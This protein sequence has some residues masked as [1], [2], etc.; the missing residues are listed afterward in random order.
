[1][2]EYINIR[3][4]LKDRLAVIALNL[5]GMVFMALF[6]LSAGNSLDTVLLVIGMWILTAVLYFAVSFWAR[7]RYLMG[8]IGLADRLQEKYLVFEII[9]RP[10]R[11]DDE[12]FYWLLKS[13]DKSML[14]KISEI[15]QEKQDYKEY[16]E[17]WVH[18]AKT[19]V[20]AMRLICEN[21][22][23]TVP[24]TLLAELERADQYIEQALFFAR[25]DYTHKDYI[26]RETCL[27]DIVHQAVAQNRQLLIQN[28][29]RVE[30]ENS[31]VT[32]YTDGKWIV[33]IIS[34]LI[35]NAV[36]YKSDTP[37]IKITIG[38]ENG[39][40]FLTI[41]DNGIGISDDELPRVFDKGFTGT[42]GRNG[43]NATGLGLYLCKRLCDKLG[44]GLSVS[45]GSEGTKFR[46]VFNG[47]ELVI[48]G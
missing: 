36:K 29:V 48:N 10:A 12:V 33:F 6:L 21:N 26:I 22:K 37:V 35:Q 7:R 44:A 38:M 11:M 32:A 47:N 5:A 23:D 14:E 45:S 20:T 19:P 34:Q 40:A 8:I 17:Q 24:R 25:S 2:R 31:E 30:V 46:L 27:E 43:E 3:R 4:Y 18:E 41:S 16:I 1:M 42:N 28:N 15:K 13:A 39:S 9:E